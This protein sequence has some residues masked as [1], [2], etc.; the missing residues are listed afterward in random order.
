M[1]KPKG[2]A[3]EYRP[4]ETRRD[5]RRLDTLIHA[6]LLSPDGGMYLVII[7]ITV[8]FCTFIFPFGGEITLAIA[9]F[10][11]KVYMHPEKRIYDF[12][13]RVPVHARL[14]DGSKNRALLNNIHKGDV[15][16]IAPDQFYGE[17]VTYFGL[18]R[19]TG[20]Q[21]YSTNSD[22]RTHLTCLGTTGSGKTEFLLGM[23]GNQLVQNSGLIYLDAKGDP[24]LQ[25]DVS[26]LARRFGRCEDILTLNFIA[27]GRNL[28]QAQS[29]KI[30]N[31]FNMM[32]KTSDGML[33][34]MLNSVLDGDSAGG[35]VWKGRAMTFI[36][37]ITRVLCY[38]RDQGILQLS[39]STY[40][41]YMELPALEELVYEHGGKYGEFFPKVAAGLQNYIDSLPGYN[42]SPKARKKQEQ[43]TIEQHGY[44]VMQLTRAIN[45]LTYNYGHIFGVKQGDIDIFDCVLNRRILTIP[46]PALER[47]PDSLKML[48][49][50][51]IGSIK[52][53][54]AGSLGNRIEGLIREILDSR[55]T[56]AP[57][58][59]KL[60]FDEFGYVVIP[61]V[62]VM[63]AQGRSL[64]FSICFAA[65]DFSDIKRG[66]ENEAEAIWGNSNVKAIGR[67][68]TGENGDTMR[69]VNGVTG[70]ELQARV[71][72][73]D[74]KIGDLGNSYTPNTSTS[75]QKEA[76]LP[77]SD[78]A[79]QE[80]GEFTL[81]ISKKE[82]GGVS[83]GVKVIRMESFYV[84]GP[85]LRHL[86]MNDL[87]PNLSITKERITDP[88]MRIQ[89]VSKILMDPRLRNNIGQ[90]I[91]LTRS[92][93]FKELQDARNDIFFKEN[94]IETLKAFLISTLANSNLDMQF[95]SPDDTD[96]IDDENSKQ[97]DYS[98]QDKEQTEASHEHNI[99]EIV[100]NSVRYKSKLE[101]QITDGAA[102]VISNTE[103][104]IKAG[105]D[106]ND[107]EPFNVFK[108][109]RYAKQCEDRLKQ[110][111]IQSIGTNNAYELLPMAPSQAENTAET[112][113]LISRLSNV[114]QQMFA[115]KSAD[116]D[117][118]LEADELHKLVAYSVEEELPA[119]SVNEGTEQSSIKRERMLR[120]I[121]LASRVK[122]Q[123]I[124]Q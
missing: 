76:V 67:I 56:N 114:Q 102:T 34:E 36:A 87:C 20:L 98:T 42:K 21:I 38:L 48:G 69:K 75:I 50:L 82:N 79:G 64:S 104:N 111:K 95:Q 88:G 33:I 77:Y 84:A 121:D 7:V 40:I 123:I 116:A 80:N 60:I 15:R 62:S 63:P 23:V 49:K 12:P 45:D 66:N 53:M 31:T 103:I 119:V 47:S 124:I 83:A 109:V 51:I 17:G 10:L 108:I 70:E 28:A 58:A 100:K 85:Q 117:L 27:S 13:W 72:S 5:I 113:G 24:A 44:I 93:A 122:A 112:D 9:L 19:T 89:A 14:F 46:L 3:A 59:F 92:P 29:D 32:N 11:N 41:Q 96:V 18:C 4:Y 61:G 115:I 78:L 54:M 91:F 106:G 35:D 26:R 37:A 101:A 99:S 55:P 90:N 110:H 16:K 86:R 39:P 120:L 118:A 97:P 52:Q 65:Q 2:S 73:T 6:E 107:I 57:N 94:P 68:V 43:K 1:F 74:L 22:D 105:L 8:I 30:T 71:T 81:L 25:R